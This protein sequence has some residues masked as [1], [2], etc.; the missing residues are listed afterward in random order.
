MND[1]RDFQ[2]GDIS[3]QWTIPRH[4][5]NSVFPTSSRSWRD[6]KPS[7]ETDLWTA[8][9]SRQ[10]FGTPMVCRE[11]VCPS[12]GV[13]FITLSAR[14]Q[15][16]D[17]QRVGTHHRMQQVNAKHQTQLLDPRC[18]LGPLVTSSF[19]Q[20]FFRE[21]CR[22]IYSCFSIWR[23]SGIRFEVGRNSINNDANPTWWHLGRIVQIKNTRVRNSR[24]SWNCMTWRFI[25][26]KMDVI[27]THWRQW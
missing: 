9:V 3:T 5:S 27:I 26:R 18:Q 16:V 7:S 1:L 13:C 21:I 17:F 22:P 24:Q 14:V 25:R 20:W 19:D 10:V 11:T 8:M 2:D 6:A 15:S 4:Q 23:Y 12:N